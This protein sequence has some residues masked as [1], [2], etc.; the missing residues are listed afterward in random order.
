MARVRT[1]KHPKPVEPEDE[2]QGQPEQ[3]E[4]GRETHGKVTS[5]AEAV[6]MAVAQGVEK[7]GDI[8]D[9][10]KKMFGVEL[11]KQM[12]SSY[13][14]QAKARESRKS[15]RPTVT[16]RSRG[17]SGGPVVENGLI[18]DISVVKDLVKRLGAEQVKQIVD[19]FE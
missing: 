18:A 2:S 11:T 17:G 4:S 19:L 15:G 3:P 10:A 6:R 7:P 5:K 16:Q 14:A 12:A 13:K 1:A 9:Y 8:V